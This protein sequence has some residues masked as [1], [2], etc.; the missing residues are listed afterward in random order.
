MHSLFRKAALVPGVFGVT[1]TGE[2]VLE[3]T[4]VDVEQHADLGGTGGEDKLSAWIVGTA[5]GRRHFL[6]TGIPNDFLYSY[7]CVYESAVKCF[8]HSTE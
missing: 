2:L 7:S 5:C 3:S 1:G 4:L 6:V 8:S